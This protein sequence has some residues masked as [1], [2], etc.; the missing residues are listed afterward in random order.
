ME[1]RFGKVNQFPEI[2]LAGAEE[3]LAQRGF[4]PDL[5]HRQSCQQG[6]GR[7]I[8]E[9]GK[10]RWLFPPPSAALPSHSGSL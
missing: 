10:I 6:C 9:V 3:M 7:V 5:W 8:K 4:L 2:N 1:N